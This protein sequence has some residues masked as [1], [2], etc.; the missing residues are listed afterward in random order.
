MRRLIPTWR[1]ARRGLTASLLGASAASCAISQQEEVA[2]GADVAAQIA[3]ELP[4][5]TNSAIVNYINTL[6]N[7]LARVTDDRGLTWRF[8]V[9]DSKE[10]NAFAVPGGWVYLN[11][12]LI[13]RATNMSQVAGVLAHEIAHITERHSVQ[14]LQKM[15]GANIGVVLACTLTGACGG[16]AA[17]AAI[18]I[19]GSALFA[20]FSRS[21]EAEADAEAVST[22][23]KAGISPNGIPGM[24]RILLA[25]RQR[26]PGALDAF[27][28]SHPLAE[29]RIASTEALIAKYSA[30]Q[31]RG[32]TLETAAFQTF[33]RRL[34][35][36]PPSPAPRTR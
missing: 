15:Q 33:R 9:V 32:L 10:V 30:A 5:I 34:L 19:G 18:G 28:A 16:G 3:A 35:A 7:Q 12:G 11:R 25:E 36:M 8:H 29:D 2:L 27:F 17:Q 4:L 31:L 14:Q 20:K 26:N 13:E 21:D 1:A 23:V 24:F 6:G 22:T